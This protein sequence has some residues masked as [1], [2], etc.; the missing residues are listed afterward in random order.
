MKFVKQRKVR[1]KH[2]KPEK[3]AFLLKVQLILLTKIETFL[4]IIILK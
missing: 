1:R 4:E 3:I 2:F